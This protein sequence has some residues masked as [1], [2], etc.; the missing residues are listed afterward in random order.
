MSC[1]I[2]SHWCC[3]NL[4]NVDGLPTSVLMSTGALLGRNSSGANEV[5]ILVQVR[6]SMGRPL[7]SIQELE[8][9]PQFA[10]TRTIFG[11]D[12]SRET[13]HLR[14]GPHPLPYLCLSFCQHTH[15]GPWFRPNVLRFHCSRSPQLD[16]R[17]FI[18]AGDSAGRGPCGTDD[19]CTQLGRG[20]VVPLSVPHTA[21]CAQRRIGRCIL[22]LGAPRTTPPR[23]VR[24][25]SASSRQPRC[26]PR[27]PRRSRNP[28]AHMRAS[29]HAFT[30]SEA[31]LRADYVPGA[32]SV[33]DAWVA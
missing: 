1:P 20:M 2:H 13:P 4:P 12:S 11:G 25:M 17:F 24:D 3:E 14:D 9:L 8:T 28:T 31:C 26:R 32:R 29:C 10:H 7:Q 15:C 19:R 18:S 30:P 27:Q 23:N 5:P 33:A 21:W 22:L 16:A 6:P